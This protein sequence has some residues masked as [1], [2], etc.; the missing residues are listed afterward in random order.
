M[1]VPGIFLKADLFGNGERKDDQHGSNNDGKLSVCVPKTTSGTI[2]IMVDCSDH[3]D[4]EQREMMHHSCGYSSCH[5]E[6]C[7]EIQQTCS[8]CCIHNN[9]DG[10][11]G[12]HAPATTFG[13]LRVPDRVHTGALQEPRS[14]SRVITDTAPVL[15][16]GVNR[17]EKRPAT[18]CSL[19]LMMRLAIVWTSSSL[20][21]E[22][23]R[24]AFRTHGAQIRRVENGR[25][26]PSTVHR[27][28]GVNGPDEDLELRLHPLCLFCVVAHD[29]E[30]SH[31]LTCRHQKGE[32]HVLSKRLGQ[33]DVVALFNE[34]AN[35]PGVTV[36]VS[37]GK[38]LTTQQRG[39]S[40]CSHA[41][42]PLTFTTSEI[43]FHCSG[44]GSTPASVTPRMGSGGPI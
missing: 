6:S 16:I 21:A 44:L 42:F 39:S 37:A 17:H 3:C 27:G 25:G 34:V 7:R 5:V 22:V 32:S 4:R 20:R 29:G 31:A 28:V 8:Q 30:A 38:A 15:N 36:N 26:D 13:L 1:S 9:E 2:W 41:R 14:F 24:A 33:Q 11:Y 35:G 23:K 18:S 10:P 40:K 12:R 19:I 43:S